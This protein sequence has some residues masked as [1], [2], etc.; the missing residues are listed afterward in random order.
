MA[1]GCR[2]KRLGKQRAQ[3]FCDSDI[4]LSQLPLSQAVMDDALCSPPLFASLSAQASF[5]KLDF[6][7]L[8]AAL[9]PSAWGPDSFASTSGRFQVPG[10]PRFVKSANGEVE[11]PSSKRGGRRHKP[12]VA[13]VLG[14]G[15]APRYEE[16]DEAA[17]Q[18]VSEKRAEEGSRG[19]KAGRQVVKEVRKE[20]RTGEKEIEEAEKE[21]VKEKEKVRRR[22]AAPKLRVKVKNV[23]AK[24]LISGAFAGAVSRT[25]V[26]PLETLRTHLMVGSNGKNIKEVFSN[27]LADEGWQGLFRGN[28]VNVLRVAPSKAIEVRN[29]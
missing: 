17:E 14:F 6:H 4:S 10:P 28:G 9:F 3:Q 26:A 7:D 13:S 11:V 21:L 24:R 22:L 20:V 27:I 5:G 1:F 29:L 25:A 19:E 23:A 2:S 15:P 12:P 8:F 16:F 18:Y